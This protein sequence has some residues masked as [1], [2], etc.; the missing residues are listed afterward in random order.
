MNHREFRYKEYIRELEQKLVPGAFYEDC[1]FYPMVCIG[2]NKRTGSL[3]GI[4]LVDGKVGHCSYRHCG[5]RIL[6]PTEALRNRLYG[7]PNSIIEGVRKFEE[8]HPEQRKAREAKQREGVWF[9][10][11]SPEDVKFVEAHVS[12]KL[13]RRW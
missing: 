10:W 9:P 7:M 6:T 2:I 4:S 3:M 11:D 5:V 1:R 12:R 8:G 13:R